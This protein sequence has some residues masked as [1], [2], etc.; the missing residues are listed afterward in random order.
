MARIALQGYLATSGRDKVGFSIVERDAEGR[1]A[2]VG[3]TRG[4][5]ERNTMRYY[6]AL[7]AYLDSLDAPPGES[8]DRRLRAWY[9]AIERYPV[10]LQ[11]ELSRE[12]Y[13]RLKRSRSR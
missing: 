13:L 2:Y 11:E 10:Q 8:L 4:M 6:L 5:L 12:E 1:P 9:A 7:E 3:G